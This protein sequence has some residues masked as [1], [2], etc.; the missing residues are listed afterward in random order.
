M[1]ESFNFQ[2]NFRLPNERSC[3][4]LWKCAVEHHTFFR[5]QVTPAAAIAASS[6]LQP[7][8]ETETDGSENRKQ[9]RNRRPG[10]FRL[11]S[12]FRYR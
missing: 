6:L 9:Q 11:G 3:K 1:S 5:L 10:L 4:H 2:Q 8:P 7:K 12:R